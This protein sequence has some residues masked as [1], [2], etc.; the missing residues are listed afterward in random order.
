MSLAM[1]LVLIAMSVSYLIM[2]QRLKTIEDSFSDIA[3]ISNYSVDI[4]K[5]NKDTTRYMESMEQRGWLYWDAGLLDDAYESYNKVIKIARIVNNNYA[6]ANAYNN[7]AGIDETIGRYDKAMENAEIALS[8][9]DDLQLNLDSK[10]L[11]SLVYRSWGQYDKY[12]ETQLEI[13]LG[14]ISSRGLRLSRQYQDLKNQIY[15]LNKLI[16]ER[17]DLECV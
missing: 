15:V 11:I 7:L 9:S 6:V 17:L 2:N 10:N 12:L 1:V 5:I 14:R 13:E 3:S 4:L 16:R 8:T